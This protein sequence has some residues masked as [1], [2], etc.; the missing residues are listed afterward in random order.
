MWIIIELCSV[1]VA[2]QQLLQVYL[3]CMAVTATPISA[4]SDSCWLWLWCCSSVLDPIKARFSE[5]KFQ[6]IKVEG[7]IKW[8]WNKVVR[9]VA[10]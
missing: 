3:C 10:L 8:R 2:E 4:C 5:V 9:T 6:Q 1:A 7:E